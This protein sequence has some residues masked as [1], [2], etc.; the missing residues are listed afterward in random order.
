MP[1]DKLVEYA[2]N[3]AAIL[4]IWPWLLVAVL[5]KVAIYLAFLGSSLYIVS[6]FLTTYSKT[7]IFVSCFLET[8]C[9]LFLYSD[10][11]L[12]LNSSDL[13]KFSYL[14]LPNSDQLPLKSF[15][16]NS[17]EFKNSL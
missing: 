13:F 10:I 3:G 8:S 6:N 7:S 9:Q 15:G 12:F 1:L 5:K 14:T 17:T 4:S 16:K 11:N 2:L